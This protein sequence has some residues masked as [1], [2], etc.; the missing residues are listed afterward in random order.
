VA[1]SVVHRV[2]LY[3]V[4]F[5]LQVED[6]KLI[7]SQR[8]N[9]KNLAKKDQDEKPRQRDHDVYKYLHLFSTTTPLSI[10]NNNIRQR[11]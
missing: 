1:A 10:N 4:S 3:I 8:T 9:I 5:A 7:I 11:S 2:A 6:I